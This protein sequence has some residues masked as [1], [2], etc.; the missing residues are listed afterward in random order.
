M[1]NEKSIKAGDILVSA[2][3]GLAGMVAINWLLRNPD[4]ARQMHM[5]IA[6]TVKR[7]AY[8]Q[9]D[10]WQGI[11]AKAATRYNELRNVSV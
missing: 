6:L 8:I 7:V 9:A 10:M 2:A 5:R 11:G 4:A 3:I 1:E